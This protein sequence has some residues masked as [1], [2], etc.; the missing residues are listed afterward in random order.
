MNNQPPQSQPEPEET[1]SLFVCKCGVALVTQRAR[2][3]GLCIVCMEKA[4]SAALTKVTVPA[5]LKWQN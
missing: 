5:R 3:T 1:P 2:K 4:L